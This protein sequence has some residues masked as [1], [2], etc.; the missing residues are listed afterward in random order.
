MVVPGVCGPVGQ[1]DERGTTIVVNPGESIQAA[2][3]AAS[4]GDTIQLVA[5]THDVVQTIL[6]N[7]AVTVTAAGAAVVRGTHAN[8]M[9][10]FELSASNAAIANLDVTWASLLESAPA[11]TE[12]ADSLVRVVGSGLSGVSITGNAIYL[13]AQAGA[14]KTWVGRALTVNDSACS[15]TVVISG[16]TIYNTRNGVVVRGNNVANI[17]DN[18]IYATKGGIMNYTASLA[19]AANRTMSNNTWGTAH[20]E[21]DIVWNT[22]SYF[23][24]DYQQ[25]VIALSSLNNGA[26]VVDRRAKDAA[27]CAS[28]T[29]NRSHLF[30]SAAGTAVAGPV[31]GN[32]NEPFPRLSLGVD[33][34]TPGGTIYVSPG[35][36]A[37]NVIVYKDGVTLTS[38]GGPA[39]TILDAGLVDKSGYKNQW[40]KGINYTWAETYDPGLLRN[41]FLVW[42]DNVTIDGFTITNAAWPTYNRGIAVL[43]GSIE[44]TYAGFIPWNIDQWGGLISPVDKPTPTGVTIRNMVIEGPS[45]GI[46]V[47]SSSGNTI[48]G[49]TIRNTTPLGGAGIIVY[50][51]GT[52]NLIQGNSVQNAAGDAVAICGVWP[53]GFL[54][55]GGTQVVSK[56]PL[57]QRERSQVLQRRGPRRKRGRGALQRG[58]W[59]RE[60]DPCRRRARHGSPCAL[61]QHH[62]EHGIRGA[63]HRHDRRL[64]CILELVG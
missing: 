54:D 29:G 39:A 53:D 6:V 19:D 44:T 3:N 59:E 60:R 4:P 50:Q 8:A 40:G 7:K 30:V 49:N 62:G 56:R 36:Y 46:Y 15:G 22:F 25:S 16:N 61:Q 2:I 55:V 47:W 57:E 34:V 27:T 18:L 45:D 12:V 32:P 24:P 35:T 26:Y 23:T 64:R 20:N 9:C 14:M 31:T 13:P 58:F 52:G 41:G 43:V 42:S 63:E 11:G 21:W 37:G 28:L 38:T 48:E 17:S 10:V 51:G 33:A 5:G 1:R